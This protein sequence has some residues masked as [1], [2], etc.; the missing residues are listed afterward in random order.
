MKDE[1]EIKVTTRLGKIITV[2]KPQK[3]VPEEEHIIPENEYSAVPEPSY[4]IEIESFFDEGD[5]HEV[6][7]NRFQFKKEK[8]AILRYGALSVEQLDFLFEHYDLEDAQ[9]RIVIYRP[10][11]QEGYGTVRC[12]EDL[13]LY[14]ELASMCFRMNDTNS[15]IAITL[16]RVFD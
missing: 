10:Y 3:E 5:I 1:N 7:R 9:K 11:K 4:L 14:N 8:K 13:K 15:V 6:H 12:E 2:K 16:Y